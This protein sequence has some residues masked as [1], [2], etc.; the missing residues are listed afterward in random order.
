MWLVVDI[1]RRTDLLDITAVHNHNSI[2]HGESFFLIV[3]NVDK[4]D[5]QLIF[6][7]D[8]FVLHV[9][10]HLEI[11]STQG[12]VEKKH[13]RFIDNG[14]GNGDSLLLT[15][16]Q[17]IDF[18]LFIAIQ[19]HQFQCIFDLVINI[20]FAFLFYPETE[21]NVFCH[22]HIREEGVFLKYG[23]QLA[24]IRSQLCDVF[25]VKD[26]TSLIRK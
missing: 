16:A 15:T 25:S 17:S 21:G 8:Q 1:F 2:G 3:G 26:N 4:C 5:S 20:G 23:I 6:Q 7:T 14:T 18:T 12:L 11:Q 9:L 13:F 22:I 19:I 10:A 24:F